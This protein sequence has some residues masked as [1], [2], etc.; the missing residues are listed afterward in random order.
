MKVPQVDTTGIADTQ[1]AGIP[2]INRL[3]GTPT[4]AEKKLLALMM[5][6]PDVMD[7]KE[8]QEAVEAVKKERTGQ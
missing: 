1:K 4:E 2:P 6:G 7:T 8:Y 3:H 5:K